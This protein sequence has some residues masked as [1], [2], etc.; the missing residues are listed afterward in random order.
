MV[1]ILVSEAGEPY[2]IRPVLMKN[3]ATVRIDNNSRISGRRCWE[4]TGLRALV[5]VHALK[6]TAHR[7]AIICG[8]AFDF[9]IF[10]LQPNI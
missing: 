10:T 4:R 2:G 3:G 7:S 9:K 6:T 5:V 1:I 8:I